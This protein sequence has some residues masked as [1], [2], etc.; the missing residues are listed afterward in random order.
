MIPS[1]SVSEPT[2]PRSSGIRSKGNPNGLYPRMGKR[3][4]DVALGL[5]A[6][7]LMAPVL[8]LLALALWIESGNP[9]FSQARLGKD[10]R[11]F[12]MLKLR[13][14]VIGADRKL[15][16]CLATNPELRREWDLT[17]KLKRDPRVTPLGRFLRRTSLDELPQIFNVL[18]GDMSLVGPRPMLPEQLPLYLF[19]EAYLALRPGITGLWQ[20]T[21]RNEEAFALRATL[22]QTYHQDLS[23]RDDLRIIG[24]TFGAVV[25][26]TGY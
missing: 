16:E 5:A 15:A 8:V 14:M 11:V 6:L 21:A 2:P 9:F 7:M 10:G 17:Q 19:P 12:R 26:A 25:M 3:A 4:L 18:K 22:D 1:G 13:T 24:A 23:L 20:V